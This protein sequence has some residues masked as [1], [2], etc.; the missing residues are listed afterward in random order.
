MENYSNP[1]HY[2]SADGILIM[3]ERDP[4]RYLPF[5]PGENTALYISVITPWTHSRR[6]I[7]T[8]VSCRGYL[9]R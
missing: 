4:K 5:L 6:F 1:L 8:Q 7:Y 3:A 2:K 9:G